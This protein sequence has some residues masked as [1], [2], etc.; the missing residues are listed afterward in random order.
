MTNEICFMTK[1]CVSIAEAVEDEKI[2]AEIIRN[3][4][5]RT[6]TLNRCYAINC[7]ENLST[8]EKNIIY[9]KVRREVE[10]ELIDKHI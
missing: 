4:I 10:S 7:Y 9:D 6:E 2:K 3:D 5:I 1:N 8:E